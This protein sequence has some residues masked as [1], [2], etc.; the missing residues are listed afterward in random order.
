MNPGCIPLAIVF[1]A[2]LPAHGWGQVKPGS[3]V[4][5]GHDGYGQVGSTP[6]GTGF[7]QIATGKHHSLALK[8][9]GAIV[10]WGFSGGLSNAPTGTG[11][12]YV[13][14]GFNHSMALKS[15][16]S[17]AAWGGDFAGQRSN[18]PTGTGFVQLAAGYAQSIA[19]H[20]VQNDAL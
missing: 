4:S 19:L 2:M 8:S 18:A 12:T 7:V 17:I 15:D 20:S 5:W 1:A 9:D 14:G 10:G 16:G 3:V 11:F 6:T 13:A